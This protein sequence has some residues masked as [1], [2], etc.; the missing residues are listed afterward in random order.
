MLQKLLFNRT[1]A[2]VFFAVGLSQTPLEFHLTKVGN[3]EHD[4]FLNRGLMYT[5]N[6]YQW[7]MHIPHG[8]GYCWMGPSPSTLKRVRTALMW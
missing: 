7:G 1:S 8:K 2:R 4:K 3:M 5:S 6:N